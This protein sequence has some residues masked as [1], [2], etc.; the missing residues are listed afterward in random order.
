[1]ADT[2]VLIVGA[3]PTGLVLALWLTEMG[4]R[5]RIVDKVGEPG[6]TSRALAV[7]ARTLELY[8]PLD[9]DS[10][11]VEKGY[12]V[13]GARLWLGGKEVAR[14]PFE[15][16]VSDLTPYGFLHIFPQDE[17]ERLLIDRLKKRGVK[18]ERP[19]ELL[20]YTERA[21]GIEAR[22]R[23]PGGTDGRAMAQF[24]AGCDGAHSKVRDVMKSGF[25]GGTY[26]QVFYVA[27][28][29]GDGPP[30]TAT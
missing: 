14:V 7:H 19:V 30:S 16:I 22:L 4:V 1:M 28:V 29:D 9:L 12:T 24:V 25:P 8:R 26:A 23:G 15:K 11:V 27:D 10:P 2:E 5:V 17:H 18:I 13:P 20:D 21:D 6:T 3:G